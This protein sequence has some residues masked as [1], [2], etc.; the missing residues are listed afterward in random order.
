[1]NMYH[2]VFGTSGYAR[3]EV[4]L[5]ILGFESFAKVGRFRDCWIE[6][7]GNDELAIAIYTRNGGGNRDSYADQIHTMRNNPNYLSDKDDSF[8]STYATF[9]FKLPDDLDELIVATLRQHAI[10]PVNMDEVWQQ[11]IETLKS[12]AT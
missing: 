9:Y 2:M 10:D 1:M 6:R 12:E 3:A 11:T 8:D 4:L 5:P 7:R